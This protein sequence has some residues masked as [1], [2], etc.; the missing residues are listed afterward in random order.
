[1][2]NGSPEDEKEARAARQGVSGDVLWF[3]QNGKTYLTQERAI[4]DRMSLP[5]KPLEALPQSERELAA[6]LDALAQHQRLEDLQKLGLVSQSTAA[7][8]Y[9]A[10]AQRSRAE[11]V[12]QIQ[13]AA[14]TLAQ[15]RAQNRAS[16]QNL[17]GLKA[18]IAALESQLMRL[19]VQLERMRTTE[20]EMI[21]RQLELNALQREVERNAELEK[22]KASDVLELLREAVEA[23]KAKPVQ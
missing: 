9:R 2:V 23:G 18:E 8:A 19:K 12:A 21:R 7:E 15:T 22:R 17:T 10:L 13:E 1:V 14:K 5:N 4:L 11:A 20:T 16:E 6:Y 3:R